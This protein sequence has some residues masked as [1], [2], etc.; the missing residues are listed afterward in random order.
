MFTIIL[1]DTEKYQQV[2]LIENYTDNEKFLAQSDQ[3]HYPLLSQLTY[4]DEELFSND[5]LSELLNEIN[6]LKV[7][8]VNPERSVYL[9]DVA[10]MVIEA[11]K[12]HKSILITPF[13]D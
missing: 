9:E 10:N 5:E 12:T 3:E 4:C 11:I 13:V 2:K 6:E 8:N 1:W 7:K